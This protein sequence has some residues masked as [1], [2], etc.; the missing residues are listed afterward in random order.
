MVGSVPITTHVIHRVIVMP[1]VPVA[2]DIVVIDDDHSEDGG[3][4][5]I[6]SWPLSA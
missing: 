6:D 2:I 4:A 5:T 3:I 1:S